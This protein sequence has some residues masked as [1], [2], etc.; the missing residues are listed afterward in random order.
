M[1]MRLGNLGQYGKDQNEE[2]YDPKSRLAGDE[3][4][5]NGLRTR[6]QVQGHLG[7]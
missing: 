6:H 7:R 2:N 3:I 4:M 5:A 1:I